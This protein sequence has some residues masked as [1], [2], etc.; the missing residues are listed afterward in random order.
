L[1]V[2][3]VSKPETTSAPHQETRRGLTLRSFVIAVFALLLLG[4]WVE[5]EELYCL[6]GGPLTENAPPNGAIGVILILLALSA[7]LYLLRRSLRLATAEMVFILAALFVAAPLMT[8]GMWHRIPGLLAS[9]PHNED[10]KSYESL[11]PMLWP[12]GSNM[13]EGPFNGKDTLGA[14]SREG[15]GTL[16]WTPMA[17]PSSKKTL[18]CPTLVNAGTTD[19][20]TLKLE[21]PVNENGRTQLV[22][23]ENYLFSCLVKTDGFQAGSSYYVRMQAD[24]DADH[25]VLLSS[26]PSAPS[27]SLQQGFQRIGKCPVQ[28]PVNLEK[29][30]TLRIGLT[31]PGKLTVQ[32]VQFFSSQAI[33]G[34]YTGVKVRRA[35]VYGDLDKSERDFTLK[36]PDSLFSFGGL[37]YLVQGFIPLAQWGGPALAWTL[38]I[39]ALFLGFMGFNV[40]MRRQWSDS[41]RFTFPM[42]ILPRQLLSEETDA[43]G[44]PYLAIFRDKVMWIGFGLM[45]LLCVLKGLHFYNPSVPA[46]FYDTFQLNSLFTN[47]LIKVYLTNASGISISFTMLAIALLIETDILFSMWAS[48]L[49]FQFTQVFGKAFNW[50]KFAGYP[51]DWQ[52]TIGAFIGYAMVALVA[53]RRHLGRI[54]RHLIGKERL[55]DSR[56]VVSYRVAVIMLVASI[57]LIIGWGV[58]TRMGW[59]AS[60]LFFSYMLIIGFTSSKVRA[61]AGMPFAYWMPYFSMLFVAAIGGFA[62][63]GTTGMLVATIASGFMCV[64][65]FFFIAP[66][67]VE[68]MELGRHFQVKARDIGA[69]LWLG[70]LGGIFIGGFVVLCWAYGFGAD[71]M[72][73]TWPY[74]QNWYFNG[75]RNGEAA[76]DRAFIADPAQ[77][78]TPATEP[79]NIVQNVDAKGITIGVGVTG[80]LATLRSLFMWFPLHPL[81]YVLSTTYFMRG[82]WFIMLIAWLIR[83][84]V[85]RIGG[86][87][88]IRKGLIPF[89]VGMFLACVVSI[90]LFDVVGFYLR[91][92]GVTNIYCKMP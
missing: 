40:L 54:W 14:F 19:Q 30:L 60:L 63:F 9:I 52:Q 34:L 43:K 62:V 6:Y 71:N 64:S 12:H 50:N 53:A 89:C 20:T 75:Y 58:W 48:F 45:M 1:S 7:L 36:R 23:G 81:G 59:V 46:P 47:P 28:I 39:G 57:V 67:Q 10:F 27:F 24:A 88:S 79:M 78:M 41:E 4:I 87:H 31:G 22:P 51:W 56:E 74:G 18:D 11:P 16:A 26:T 82:A 42:N 2:T 65:C 32:D 55:D 25:T 69:G 49:L 29:K 77:L 17:W 66:V 21:I 44:H 68:M 3:S 84:I 90:M 72:A 70:L 83:L 33:E 85:L 35:S 38:L 80:L 15:T 92:I 8:Q 91:S 5:Y 86:A 37:A 76:I 61:E 73:T 13:V